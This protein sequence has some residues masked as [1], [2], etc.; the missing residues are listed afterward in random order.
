[1]TAEFLRQSVAA[2][3]LLQIGSDPQLTFVFTS[4]EMLP[5]QLRLVSKAT[6]QVNLL[7]APGQF[8]LL[9][10]CCGRVANTFAGE[11]I[12]GAAQTCYHS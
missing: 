3:C 7:S 1:L 4:G 12:Q 5:L 10:N 8:E 2:A 9:L 11:V 6:A